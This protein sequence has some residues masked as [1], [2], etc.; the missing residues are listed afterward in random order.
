MN[1]LTI[2]VLFPPFHGSVYL[3]VVLALMRVSGFEVTCPLELS[4]A[5]E[6]ADFA[7][8]GFWSGF[9]VSFSKY[10]FSCDLGDYH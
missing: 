9:A 6:G 8:H 10:I 3:I 1:L 5:C 4:I 7:N 2:L